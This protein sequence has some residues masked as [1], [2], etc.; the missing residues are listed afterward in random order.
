[1]KNLTVIF[2]FCAIRVM[3]NVLRTKEA[4]SPPVRK[5]ASRALAGLRAGGT[6]F[7]ED[8]RERV[9]L[10]PQVIRKVEALLTACA[11]GQAPSV[12]APR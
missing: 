9:S 8:G 2:R 3:A 6:F 5:A 7:V 12:L 1:M 10:P 11:E 4:V